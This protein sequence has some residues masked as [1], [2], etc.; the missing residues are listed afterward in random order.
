MS[1]TTAPTGGS[2]NI[3]D[4]IEEVEKIAAADKISI[5]MAFITIPERVNERDDSDDPNDAGDDSNNGDNNNAITVLASESIPMA[6]FIG[7]IKTEA[8]TMPTKDQEE[9][10]DKSTKK[11]ENDAQEK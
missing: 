4:K 9:K 7:Q 11:L 10:Q 8:I 5:D 1:E 3:I 6:P 2:K